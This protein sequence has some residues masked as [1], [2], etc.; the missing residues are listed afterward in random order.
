M[1]YQ[2]NVPGYNYSSFF[3]EASVTDKIQ[4]DAS[5]TYIWKTERDKL[6]SF[7]QKSLDEKNYLMT[8]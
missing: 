4:N 7:E 2:Y 3:G 5:L 6:L 1:C 8:W